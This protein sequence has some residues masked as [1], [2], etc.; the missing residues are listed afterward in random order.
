MEIEKKNKKKKKEASFQYHKIFE[1]TV[2]LVRSY[3]RQS[4]PQT[5]LSGSP[6]AG[7][8]SDRVSH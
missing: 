7:A 5:G 1:H 4:A 6:I 8:E 3:A 2:A